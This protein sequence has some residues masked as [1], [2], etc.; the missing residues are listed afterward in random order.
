MMQTQSQQEHS[1]LQQEP[2]QLQEIQPQNEDLHFIDPI[3]QQIYPQPRVEIHRQPAPTVTTVSFV[4]PSPQQQPQHDTAHQRSHQPSHPQHF[5]NPEKDIMHDEDV[6][7]EFGQIENN[8][9]DRS[10]LFPRPIV[11][12]ARQA[13]RSQYPS[14]PVAQFDKS[15]QEQQHNSANTNYNNNDKNETMKKR[16]FVDSEP[17][18]YPTPP[19]YLRHKILVTEPPVPLVNYDTDRKRSR[20]FAMTTRSKLFKFLFKVFPRSQNCCYWIL[21]KF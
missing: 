14:P 3:R 20:L 9:M 19:V 12:V 16:K 11:N 21:R 5:I 1:Q 8:P 2:I 6:K 18:V 17:I 4:E 15:Q 7:D 10:S 13:M